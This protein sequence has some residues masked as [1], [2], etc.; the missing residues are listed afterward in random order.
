VLDHFRPIY[1]RR[2]TGCAPDGKR[3]ILTIA[4]LTLC[5]LLTGSRGLW[6]QDRD[7][8]TGQSDERTD[9]GDDKKDSR[10]LRRGAWSF[11]PEREAAAL[12]FVRQHHRELSDLLGELKRSNSKQYQAAIRDLFRISERLA[13]WKERDPKRYELELASWKLQSRIQLLLAQFQMGRDSEQL[14]HE[15]TSALRRQ[16]ALQK[17]R[18]A[19]ERRLHESRLKKIDSQLQRLNQNEDALVERQLKLLLKRGKGV[20]G[21]SGK[22]RPKP[23]GKTSP[24][25]RSTTSPSPSRDNS[26]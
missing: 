21:R 11:T 18:L 24:A 25:K 15:L 19:Y 16:L 3:A 2:L 23:D 10:E 7:R 1:R 5:F 9:S 26:S 8:N 20:Q 6:A 22:N 12:T 13:Q 14:K 4:L 17:E